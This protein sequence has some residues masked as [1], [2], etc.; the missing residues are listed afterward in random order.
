MTVDISGSAPEV[1]GPIVLQRGNVGLHF[2]KHLLRPRDGQDEDEAPGVVRRWIEHLRGESY[3]ARL[4]VP[5]VRIGDAKRLA[6]AAG[7]RCALAAGMAPKGR[8]IHCRTISRLLVGAGNAHVSDVGMTWHATLGCPYVPGASIKGAMRAFSATD[9][10]G[11]DPAWAARIFGPSH[12]GTLAQ[13][14]LIVL[15]A[16]PIAPVKLEVDVLTPHY[17]PYYKAPFPPVDAG[18]RWPETVERMLSDPHA[19]FAKEK[20]ADWHD[21]LPV[22]FLTVGPGAHFAF[23]LAL[24]PGSCGPGEADR[25]LDMAEDILEC[26]L[27]ESGLGAKTAAGYGRFERL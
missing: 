26:V 2:Q 16:I 18:E 27:R 19:A 6:R 22:E 10:G 3:G 4:V 15:D 11:V 25:Y 23:A 14:D 13:G 1:A 21:P 20:P 7:R 12:D 5:T 17:G 24:V 9:E 8:T